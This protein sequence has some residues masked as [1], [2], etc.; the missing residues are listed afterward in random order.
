MDSETKIE[1]WSGS[2]ERRRFG[3]FA[4]RLPVAMCRD[5]MVKQG[6]SSRLAKCRLHIQDFSLGGLSAESTIPLKLNENLTL[7]LPSSGLRPAAELTGRVVHCR[8]L[9]NR[10]QIGIEF[11]QTRPEAAAS[12]WY[13]LSSLFSLASQFSNDTPVVEPV[14]DS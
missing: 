7:R 10:Y 4:T 2:R 9:S 12:P 5:N 13:R 6:Q 3:R 14:M 8:R 11:C 1:T